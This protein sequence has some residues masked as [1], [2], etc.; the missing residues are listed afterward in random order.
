MH[1]SSIL[2]LKQARIEINNNLNHLLCFIV[3]HFQKKLCIFVFK[4]ED[5]EGC[6]QQ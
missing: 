6:G 4:T 5:K 3:T 1:L 2:H